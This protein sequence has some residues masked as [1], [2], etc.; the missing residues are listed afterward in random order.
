MHSEEDVEE[1]RRAMADATAT[2]PIK[3]VRRLDVRPGDAL[4]VRVPQA[5]FT[6][7]LAGH[8]QKQLCGL[9]GDGVKV[10]VT[11]GDVDITV[12]REVPGEAGA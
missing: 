1:M 10:V 9:F 6:A 7:Q 5:Q 4:V 3:D 8:I 11:P 2:I 12:V